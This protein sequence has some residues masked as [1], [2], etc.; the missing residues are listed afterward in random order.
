MKPDDLILELLARLE[1]KV[2]K[3]QASVIACQ[4]R[5]QVDEAIKRATGT[6]KAK[7]VKA[8]ALLATAAAG[9]LA[10]RLIGN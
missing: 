4:G 10:E 3:V 1:E 2:D 6:S 7:L 9:F 8:L 5:C